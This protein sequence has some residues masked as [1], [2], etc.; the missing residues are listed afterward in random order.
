MHQNLKP[1]SFDANDNNLLLVV[2]LRS[3]VMSSSIAALTSLNAS[4]GPVGPGLGLLRHLK[5]K[6]IEVT[7]LC[8][9]YTLVAMTP[10]AFGI[11]TQADA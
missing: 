4:G 6:I 5:M 2:V 1:S 11:G 10:N 3:L 9:Y 7:A 8:G